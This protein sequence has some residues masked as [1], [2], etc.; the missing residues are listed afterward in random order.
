MTIVRSI[1]HAWRRVFAGG[2]DL[3]DTLPPRAR[4]FIRERQ[5]GLGRYTNEELEEIT[6]HGMQQPGFLDAVEEAKA[7]D[8]QLKAALERGELPDSIDE[9]HPGSY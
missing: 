2:D 5:R 1:S 7:L 4:K 6:L 3:P 8:E 9:Y